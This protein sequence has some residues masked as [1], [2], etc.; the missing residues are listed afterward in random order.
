MSFSK[1]LFFVLFSAIFVLLSVESA[2]AKRKNRREEFENQNRNQTQHEVIAAAKFLN[3]T[4][5]DSDV[6]RAVNDRRKVNYVEG[7]NMV[8]VKVLPDDDNGL[9]HQKWVV[10]LSSGQ[11]MQA[12]YNSDMCPRVPVRVGDVVAMG[13][14]FLWTNSGALLHWLH[15]DP[16][17]NRPD[18]YV[19]LNGQY[20]CKD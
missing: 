8:V 20:Y 14:M 11:T 1:K 5:S 12:V 13:G 18:G 9:K 17:E 4:D 2:L 6:V 10:R 16:R 3:S 7:G 15:H 19:Y